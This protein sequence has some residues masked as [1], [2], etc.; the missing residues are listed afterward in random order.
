MRLDDTVV[1]AGTVTS[2]VGNMTDGYFV[3]KRDLTF[4]HHMYWRLHIRC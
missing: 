2:L 1:F 3:R 4:T